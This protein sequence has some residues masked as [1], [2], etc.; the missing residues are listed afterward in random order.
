[1]DAICQTFGCPPSVAL[2]QD[3]RVVLPLMEYMTFKRI[4]T[5]HNRNVS[6][7][8]QSPELVKMWLEL[9]EE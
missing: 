6:E 2:E 5:I 4:R 7:L 8:A 9:T 1:M 3:P